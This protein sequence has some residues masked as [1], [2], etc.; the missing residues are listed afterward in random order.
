M[1]ILDL[2]RDPLVHVA[3][4]GGLALLLGA[5]ALHKLH[6]QRAFAEVL[7]R[8]A[9]VLGRWCAAALWLHLLPVLE[10]LA[11]V[12]VLLSLYWPLAALPALALLVLYAGVLAAAVSDGAAVEDCGCHFG[13]RRQPPSQALVWRNLLLALAAGNLLAT[14]GE[15]PLTWLDGFTLVFAFIS[16]AALYLLA[17]QLIA[18]R[19]TPRQRP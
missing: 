18:N 11:A 13:A 1:V 9:Q 15:R 10:V 12:G 16:V 4:A 3:S 6:D 17:N 5:A 7:R 2:L 14:V 19:A 8:Y